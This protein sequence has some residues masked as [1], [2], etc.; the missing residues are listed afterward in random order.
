MGP[1]FQ[2]PL[3]LIPTFLLLAEELNISRCA[4]KLGVSQPALTRQ[5][6][7]LEEAFG[8]QLFVRQ[9][10]GVALT[11][12]GRSLKKEILPVFESLQSSV[13]KIRDSH[14]KLTGTLIF[15]CFSEI[16]THLI[17]P[18]LF[19]FCLS[20]PDVSLDIRYLSESEIISGIAN[21]Q[22]HLGIASIPPA[23]ESVR[24]YKLMNERIVLVT[25]TSN[26][27]LDKVPRPRFAGFRAHD[28][29]LQSYYKS[30]SAL[31]PSGPPQISVAVNSH[32]AMIN[33]V[34]RLGLYAAMP[35]HSVS[36]ALKDEQVRIAASQ[37]LVN[38]VYLLMPD[39]EFPERRSVEVIKFLKTKFKTTEGKG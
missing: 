26:S 9:S 1:S 5:L 32:Q 11:Q 19:E 31:F 4:R 10:R 16:G 28:R 34:R 38:K 20:H 6:Q 30:H 22:L 27:N 13:A 35:F 3:E 33:A 39:S 23:N 29:L 37:E 7:S 18:A 17:S 24:S 2:I 14:T 12:T 36:S 15:G 25:S 8:A 21:G